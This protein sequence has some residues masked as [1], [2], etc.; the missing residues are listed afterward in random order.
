MVNPGL[1]PHTPRMALGAHAILWMLAMTVTL[2]P[3]DA[4][5]QTRFL[6][7][8]DQVVLPVSAHAVGDVT[9]ELKAAEQN[10]RQNPLNLDVAARYARQT[11]LLGVTE[12]D[13]R[14]FGTAK[15]ALLP[16]WNKSDLNADGYFMRGL[17]KQGFH[18]FEGGLADINAAIALDGNRAEFWSWRFAIHLLWADMA[19]ARA[20]CAELGQ[21]A[22]ALEAQACQAILAYRT[23]QAAVAVQAL[24]TLVV[25]PDFQGNL[26][27]DWLRFHLG[28]AQRTAGQYAAAKATWSEHLA[29]RPQAHAIRLSLVELSNALSEHAHAK[30]L[31]ATPA[32]TD[33][34]LV[35]QLLA[36]QALGDA[37]APRLAQQVEERMAAQALRQDPLIERPKMVYLIHFG[38]DVPAGLAL[39]QDNWRAQKEPPDALLLVEAALKLNRPQEA[40]P[41]LDWMAKTGYTDPALAALAQQIKSRL[42]R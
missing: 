36:S 7:R 16:W 26:A 33:A 39:A 28:E 1:A 34:L 25:A 23:G 37:D 6:P 22:G 4:W 14:W 19:A 13:L 17:V 12:G 24:K 41:V 29:K 42:G 10:W 32:P 11:F 40:V 5:A 30:K 3:P 31:A 9:R 38:K 8:A 20:D 21:R 15:A 27:Q 18:D 2:A 35:Q